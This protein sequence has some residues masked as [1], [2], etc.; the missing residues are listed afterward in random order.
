MHQQLNDHLEKV[1]SLVRRFGAV[2]RI[3]SIKNQLKGALG[4]S[5]FLDGDFLFIEEI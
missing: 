3:I 4:F 1:I 2:D 5:V